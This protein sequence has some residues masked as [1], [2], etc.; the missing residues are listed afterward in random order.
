[1]KPYWGFCPLLPQQAHGGEFANF[2][3]KLI[4]NT[5]NCYNLNFKLWLGLVNTFYF[6]FSIMELWNQLL[7]TFIKELCL[8]VYL[9]VS[10]VRI[11][12]YVPKLRRN[13]VMATVW[14]C[15]STRSWQVQ[16]LLIQHMDAGIIGLMWAVEL[17][18]IVPVNES[19]LCGR[20]SQRWVIGGGPMS[21][22]S[23]CAYCVQTNYV[24]LVR[25]G[26]KK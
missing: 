21:V 25:N 1:M 4:Y 7:R 2:I 3:V 18:N 8:K 12:F 24:T 15:V 10:F 14:D 6:L 9:F 26:S 23:Q 22:G 20:P 19:F 5:R 11:T 17:Y 16:S 13:M